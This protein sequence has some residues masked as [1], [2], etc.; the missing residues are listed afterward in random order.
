MATQLQKIYQE[1]QDII[2]KR[3][4]LS[5]S[6]EEAT[7][8]HLKYLNTLLISLFLDRFRNQFSQATLKTY[9]NSL[10]SY[11][12]IYLAPVLQTIADKE[13]LQLDIVLYEGFSLNEVKGIRRSLKKLFQF[14]YEQQVIT[15]QEFDLDKKI[16]NQQA[17]FDPAKVPTATQKLLDQY[18][19]SF[20]NLYGAIPVNQAARIIFKQNP[21]LGLT[22]RQFLAA[23]VKHSGHFDKPRP[24]YLSLALEW[25]TI[26]NPVHL[27]TD[28][29]DEFYQRQYLLPYWVPNKHQLL[30]F[31]DSH[32]V[33]PENEA[34]RYRHSLMSHLKV[35]DWYATSI[36]HDSVAEI[37]KTYQSDFPKT[38]EYMV[39]LMAAYGYKLSDEGQRQY[40][41]N[42]FTQLYNSISQPV[43][44]GF[45]PISMQRFA[46]KR[47]D[48]VAEIH[49]TYTISSKTINAL[50]AGELD[51]DELLE[52]VERSDHLDAIQKQSIVDKVNRL[53]LPRV[54]NVLLE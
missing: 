31:A 53:K 16:L 46:A 1:F 12:N 21:A 26:V 38:V 14:L 25:P 50:K 29:L 5:Q 11:L 27:A 28:D 48:P 45:S 44:R 10:L 39:K 13:S 52:H 40:F 7:V 34:K 15:S 51:P 30:K 9:L 47:R 24:F 32:Y 41:D 19:V 36:L 42:S 3:D 8:E 23:L 18:F 43:L 4:H 6:Q 54:V 20:A 37:H 35:D 17:K 33:Y 2:N 22:V 49:R